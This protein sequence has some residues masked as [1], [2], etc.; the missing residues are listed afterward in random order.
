MF[1]SLYVLILPV[2]FLLL[3]LLLTV[4]SP[5][6][7]ALSSEV[8]LVHHAVYIFSHKLPRLEWFGSVPIFPQ[9]S[10]P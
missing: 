7:N 3:K 2:L 10:E 8:Q 1:S 5:Q 4:Q 9:R 6:C